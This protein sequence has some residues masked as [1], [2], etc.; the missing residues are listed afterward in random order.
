MS[1]GLRIGSLV[2]FAWVLNSCYFN[3][4]GHI[5]DKAAYDAIL[6]TSE[7]KA[8]SGDV[9]YANGGKY[10]IDVIMGRY[11]KPVKTQYDALEQ[12]NDNDSQKVLS[13]T[14]RQLVEIP[15]DFAMYLMGRSKAPKTPSYMSPVKNNLKEKCLTYP[16]KNTPE[17]AAAYFRYRS[18]GAFAYYTLGVLDWL[19]VDLP[20]TSVENAIAIPCYTLMGVMGGLGNS[21]DHAGRGLAKMG[22]SLNS[23][24]SRMNNNYANSSYNIQTPTVYQYVE[25]VQESAPVYQYAEPIQQSTPTYAAQTEPSYDWVPPVRTETPVST[26]FNPPTALDT[27]PSLP[28]K[29]TP[30]SLEI[31][32]QMLQQRREMMEFQNELFEENLRE[33]RE[34]F[35]S[36]MDIIRSHNTTPTYKG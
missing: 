8:D 4:A 12:K 21:L 32:R 16:I 17:S 11:D 6:I 2:G 22:N 3:S 26:T 33:R 13:R 10:Y 9:V 29:V 28:G 19:C 20:I 1:R 14:R 24:A 30:E 31:Q 5:F 25:S 36:M 23:S 15:E 18:P 35:N 7:L 34:S 27:I